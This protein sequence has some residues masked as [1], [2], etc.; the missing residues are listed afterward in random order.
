MKIFTDTDV[1]ATQLF[2]AKTRDEYLP[3]GYTVGQKHL[4]DMIELVARETDTIIKL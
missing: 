4:G 2:L 3:K 1:T